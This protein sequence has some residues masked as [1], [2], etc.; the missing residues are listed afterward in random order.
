MYPLFL[1]LE[2]KPCLV[3]GGGK[4]AERKAQ[5]LLATGAS[6]H[7]IAPSLTRQLA[8]WVA[9]GRIHYQKDNYHTQ[10]LR[11]FK[12]IISATNSADTNYQVYKDAQEQGVLINVV[13]NAALSDFYVPSMIKRGSFMLAICTSG[14]APYFS[15]KFR[16]YLDNKIPRDWDDKLEKVY[17]LRKSLKAFKTDKAKVKQIKAQLDELVAGIFR[18]MEVQKT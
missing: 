8:D 7:V 11:P 1:K 9:E 13:D 4:I 16:R 5:S 6:L 17:E 14:K 12:C 15:G 2:N 18:E 10:D 3:I